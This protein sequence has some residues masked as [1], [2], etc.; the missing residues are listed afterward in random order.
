[1]SCLG[2]NIVC[3]RSPAAALP[4]HPPLPPVITVPCRLAEAEASTPGSATHRL[5]DSPMAWQR[6]RQPASPK[7]P[8]SPVEKGCDE[9]GCAL[10]NSGDLEPAL[11]SVVGPNDSVT[12]YKMLKADEG[13]KCAAGYIPSSRSD[14]KLWSSTSHVR[15][16]AGRG[17]RLS[18][19]LHCRLHPLGAGLGLAHPCARLHRQLGLCKAVL[20]NAAERS[21]RL[22][23]CACRAMPTLPA[24]W[25]SA[26]S[27]TR[28]SR[29]CGS[30]TW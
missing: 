16:G 25:P 1:M 29:S 19:A 3:E 10:T 17:G 20:T 28:W 7:A 12:E 15:G 8:A 24:G 2:H 5:A 22:A 18:A 26:R 27:G 13:D 14:S 21:C 30:S 4:A 9:E 11:L 23:S 6:H